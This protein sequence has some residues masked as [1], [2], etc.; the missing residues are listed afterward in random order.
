[1]IEREVQRQIKTMARAVGFAV[2]DLSQG[3]RPGKRR[4]AT[5]RQTKGLSDLYLLHARR[6]LAV[7]IECKG[8]STKVTPEQR[9]FL[10]RVRAAGGHAHICRSPEDFAAVLRLFGFEVEL[11]ATAAQ[12]AS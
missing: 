8:E 11:G 1:M 12:R 3:Y 5:T 10:E 6:Q 9:I 7:W 2:Y 4:H